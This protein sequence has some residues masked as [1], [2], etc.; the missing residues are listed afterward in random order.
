MPS[1]DHPPSINQS[2]N[3]SINFL[4]P[5]KKLTPC[6][7]TRPYGSGHLNQR[8]NQLSNLNCP[9]CVCGRCN[10]NSRRLNQTVVVMVNDTYVCARGR[11]AGSSS[12][13]AMERGPHTR[14][15]PD[16]IFSRR[17]SSTI[18]IW[19]YGCGL[20]WFVTTALPQLSKIHSATSAAPC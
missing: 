13:R 9:P 10:I 7:Y 6:I 15:E 19:I 4:F 3:Q 16:R 14:A 2:I 11:P 8:S 5:H 17:P 1:C 18:L 12:T 20:L